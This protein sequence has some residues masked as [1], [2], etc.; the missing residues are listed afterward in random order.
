VNGLDPN[1]IQD[2][3]KL[4][5]RLNKEKGITIFV[6]SHLLAEI[7]RMCTH[8]GI[9]SKGKLRFEGTIEELGKIS[10]TCR[11]QLNVADAARWQEVFTS[12]NINAVLENPTQLTLSMSGR[13]AIPGLTKLLVNKGAEIYEIRILDGLE[14]W[15]MTLV[16]QK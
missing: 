9:I 2:I 15:F 13:D 16:N 6:S 3:R 5:V 12:E 8:V 14:E 4:L 7:E 11:V 10:G 1:G